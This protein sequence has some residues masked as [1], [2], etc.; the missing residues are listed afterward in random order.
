LHGFGFTDMQSY[1]ILA[2]NMTQQAYLLASDDLFWIS[3]W[4]S[5]AMIGVIWLARRAVSGGGPPVSAD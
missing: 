4:L 5:I 1:A 2:H 3:G